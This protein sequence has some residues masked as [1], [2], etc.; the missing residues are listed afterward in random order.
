MKE[1]VRIWFSDVHGRGCIARQSIKKR[2]VIANNPLLTLDVLAKRI[3]DCR[4]SFVADPDNP[5]L[6]AIAMGCISFINH[7]DTPNAKIVVDNETWTIKAIATKDIRK[8]EEV[9]IDYGQ[10]YWDHFGGKK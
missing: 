9:F 7:S 4:Y 1:K 2:H 5:G 3:E 6:N 8:G 10:E